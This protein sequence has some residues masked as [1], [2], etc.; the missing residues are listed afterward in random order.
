MAED[1]LDAKAAEDAAKAQRISVEEEL[2]ASLGERE[3]GAETHNIDFFKIVITSK[4]S[5][6]V[7]NPDAYSAIVDDLD[8]ANLN[9]IT[10]VESYKISDAKCRELRDN[11]PD[12]YAKLAYALTSKKAKTAVKV[13]RKS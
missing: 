11:D 9:P 7:D 8:D 4:I 2:I 6:K 10:I 13:E 3:E 5:R 12:L 1:W